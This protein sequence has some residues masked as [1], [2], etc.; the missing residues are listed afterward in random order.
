MVNDLDYIEKRSAEDY[1][2]DNLESIRE[3][4]DLTNLTNVKY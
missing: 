1:L 4:K 2:A 3:I